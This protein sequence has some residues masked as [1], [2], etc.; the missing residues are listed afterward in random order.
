[1]THAW[2]IKKVMTTYLSQSVDGLMGAGTET[3]HLP[4]RPEMA[5]KLRPLMVLV[6]LLIDRHTT[7]RSALVVATLLSEHTPLQHL[8]VSVPLP[9]VYGRHSTTFEPTYSHMIAAEAFDT[10]NTA[11]MATTRTSL[12]IRPSIAHSFSNALVG[13]CFAGGGVAR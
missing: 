8:R 3:P 5:P 13:A 10:S 4:G 9:V 6:R 2:N 1:M 11:N 12:L 7:S